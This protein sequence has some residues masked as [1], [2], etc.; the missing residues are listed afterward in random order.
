MHQDGAEAPSDVVRALSPVPSQLPKTRT[1]F[2]VPSPPDEDM[3]SCY[4]YTAAEFDVGVQ[5]TKEASIRMCQE[6]QQGQRL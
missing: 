4:E 6:H 1:Q 3:D 5:G 2:Q